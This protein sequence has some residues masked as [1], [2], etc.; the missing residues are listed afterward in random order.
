MITPWRRHRRWGPAAVSLVAVGALA[1]GSVGTAV[2][3]PTGSLT[4]GSLGSSAPGSLGSS[5]LGSGSGSGSGGNPGGVQVPPIDIDAPSDWAPPALATKIEP[6]PSTVVATAGQVT[7]VSGA[8]GSSQTIVYSPDG[9]IPVVGDQFVV[10]SGFGVPDGTVGAV[11]AV[12]ELGG[13]LVRVTVTPGALEDAYEQ[14]QLNERVDFSDN[15]DYEPGQGSPQ[16]RVRPNGFALLGNLL[17]CSAGD[18]SA[19]GRSVELSA[20]LADISADIKFDLFK[21][22]LRVDLTSTTTVELAVNASSAL[23]LTC[24]VNYDRAPKAKIPT[25]GP[26][27]LG[28]APAFGTEIKITGTVSGSATTVFRTGFE[29]RG[30]SVRGLTS[31]PAPSTTF[32]PSADVTGSAEVFAGLQGKWGLQGFGWNP[33]SA[34]ADFEALGFLK[35]ETKASAA[36]CVDVGIGGRIK[37]GLSAKAWKWDWNATLAGVEFGKSL[38]RPF[39]HDGG[40]TGPGPGQGPGQGPGPGHGPT[41]PETTAGKLTGLVVSPNLQ[42]RVDSPVDGRSVYYGDNSCGTS[43][44]VDG[45]S[46]GIGG[47]SRFD[48]AGQ[49]VS[50]QGTAVDPRAITTDV[51][52]GSTG[53]TLRQV[54]TFVDGSSEYLTRIAVKNTS[55]SARQLVVY[56]AADCYLGNSDHGIGEVTDRSA[57]CIADTGRSITWTDLTGGATTEENYYGTI[58]SRVG[59]ASPFNGT[60]LTTRHDN[61]AG[62]SW[63]VTLQ[64]G[65][66]LLLRSRFQ[67]LEPATPV[68][69]V[70]RHVD[71]P[72]PMKALR[73][74]GT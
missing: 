39:C 3:A 52:A 40:G 27:S 15:V 68:G 23:N 34:T 57:S 25:G 22:Y 7:A 29:A 20:S 61:G 58:W 73:A 41:Q 2:A 38:A 21:Q 54:D 46:Y 74:F 63:V 65:Q 6:K 5:G 44:A 62:I 31:L 64:P 70:Q 45:T 71:L 24:R 14:F 28:L 37:A 53:V 12:E 48:E 35:A 33:A 1:L 72:D 66:E 16:S 69:P 10:E 17:D 42:C 59:S 30:G 19:F 13:G 47:A 67:L 11:T 4:T 8:S 51:R 49:T 50:G 32:A 43:L 9:R 55:D 56:R 26:T 60:A 18:S 36:G